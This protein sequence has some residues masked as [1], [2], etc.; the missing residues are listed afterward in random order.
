[1]D[2]R[3]GARI[4][5]WAAVAATLAAIV[6]GLTALRLRSDLNGARVNLASVQERADEAQALRDSLSKLVRDVAS[7]VS[8][9]SVTLAGT[10]PDVVGR[11]RLFIDLDTG[12][13]L[14]LIDDLPVLAPDEVYQLWVIRG[15]EPHDAGAFRL[16]REGPAWIELAEAI[17]L[18]GVDLVVMTVEQAPGA[19]T[20]TGNPILAGGT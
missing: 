17:D 4:W 9:S 16:E 3:P 12:R 15:G 14:L 7:L 5:P 19:P 6:L 2:R 1:M 11:A 10:S 13:T 20:P 8:S 18:S